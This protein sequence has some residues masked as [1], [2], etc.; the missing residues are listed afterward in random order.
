[1]K[2]DSLRFNATNLPVDDFILSFASSGK[3]FAWGLNS[4]GALGLGHSSNVDSV[5]PVHQFKQGTIANIACGR[6]SIRQVAA[7]VPTHAPDV[8]GEHVTF[9]VQKCCQD[10]EEHTQSVSMQAIALYKSTD[11]IRLRSAEV[12]ASSSSERAREKHEKARERK[13]RAA[14]KVGMEGVRMRAV[15]TCDSRTGM[16]QQNFTEVDRSKSL[17]SCPHDVATGR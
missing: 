13:A 17:E 4:Y 3:L 11:E 12:K 14:T 6:S 15:I 7:V 2:G 16:A 10:L 9:V 1:M 8:T 5:H